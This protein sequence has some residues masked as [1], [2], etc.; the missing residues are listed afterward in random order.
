MLVLMGFPYPCHPF[1]RADRLCGAGRPHGSWFSEKPGYYRGGALAFTPVSLPK[2]SAVIASH[3]HFDH[4]DVDAFSAYP[5]KTVPF[6]V[7]R[8][9]GQKPGKPGSPT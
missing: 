7:K 5:E 8:G 9:M 3:D 6:V 1:V 2:L 4:Y